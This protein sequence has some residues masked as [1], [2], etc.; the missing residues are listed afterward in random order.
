[1]R[2]WLTGANGQ[3]GRTFRQ[4]VE[5]QND[6]PY[7]DLW[8]FSD[9]ADCDI[10][11]YALVEQKIT[12]FK[13]HIIVNCAAYTK[14]DLAEKER[15]LCTLI[16]VSAVENLA[17]LC[18]EQKI[19]LIH[20]SSDYVFDGTSSKAYKEDDQV[21]P[22][23]HYGNTKAQADELILKSEVNG[24]IFRTSWV[25]SQYGHNFL[26][27]MLHLGN[28]KESISVIND[29]FSC[30]THAHDLAKAVLKTIQLG[31]HKRK[32]EILNFSNSGTASW[33]D[34]ANHIF[35]REQ[36]TCEV[37]AILTESYPL[38]AKRPKYSLLSIDKFLENVGYSPPYWKDAVNEC[39]KLLKNK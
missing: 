26:K 9:S 24:L 32:A 39:L 20:F 25:Y 18:A 27:T 3:L 28:I 37:K 31:L 23:S 33:Y 12:S 34:F 22:L 6:S 19:S 7:D 8:F 15:D 36:L 35:K 38:P 30:P 14:V 29:Q 16:N 17:K 4:L 10:T 2:V 13:P 11:N 21:F 1:M 5:N